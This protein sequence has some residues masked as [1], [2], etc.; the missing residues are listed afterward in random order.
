MNILES[1]GIGKK[2]CTA[3]RVIPK[4]NFE[5][6]NLVSFMYCM[7]CRQLSLDGYEYNESLLHQVFTEEEFK[8]IGSI[9][10]D[11]VKE[12]EPKKFER[13]RRKDDSYDFHEIVHSFCASLKNKPELYFGILD[14]ACS[15]KLENVFNNENP[16]TRIKN[17]FFMANFA[18]TFNLNDSEITFL[19]LNL[20]SYKNIWFLPEP[21][22][23]ENKIK[24]CSRFLP[25]SMILMEQYIKKLNKRF[26]KLALFSDDWK[27]SDYVYNYFTGNVYPFKVTDLHAQEFSDY[28]SMDSIAAENYGDILM[29]DEFV[30]K[31]K[32]L[33]KG[34]YITVSNADTFR[35][36][37]F[38]TY[39]NH[40]NKLFTAEISSE[41]SNFDKSA[42]IFFLIAVSSQV[43]GLDV[44]LLLGKN[45]LLNFFKADT[46]KN[47]TIRIFTS[48]AQNKKE[49]APETPYDLF[50]YIHTPVFLLTDSLNSEEAK[51]VNGELKTVYNWDLKNPVQKEYEEQFMEFLRTKEIDE[52]L[53]LYMA[54]ECSHLQIAP[55]KWNDIAT[56]V[57]ILKSPSCEKVMQLINANYSSSDL[58]K[59][60]RKN[61]HYSL[62]A[63]K[64][65]EPVENIVKD[66]Q[67]AEKWQSKEYDSESG[68]RI[69]NYGPS[70]T[71]KT[72][73]VENT[74]KL[75]D[76][77]LKIVRASEILGMYVGETE[78]NIK[79]AFEDAAETNSILLIDEADSFLHSRGD[80]VNRHNDSKVNE[81][82]VQME[83]FPG[84]LFCN[85]NLPDNL[86]SA[87]DRRFH[88]KI[89]FE[90]LDKEG[91]SL[92]CKSYFEKYEFSE[93][94]I[95]EIYNSGEVTPGDFGSLFGRMRFTDPDD[96]TADFICDE[97]IKVV[98][99]KKRSWKNR[100][101]IGFGG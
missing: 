73:F 19:L 47:N 29:T 70:G 98:K 81:F 21:L 82:L 89:G 78:K 12:K 43:Q 95:N 62:D 23:F 14:Y 8:K 80:N 39:I 90:P 93:Q 34:C 40:C 69:L 15:Q 97:L 88:M 16:F 99:G 11:V 63:L 33:R 5:D 54:K 10:I 2:S 100:K 46:E 72:A 38:V 76:K 77:P 67:N 87:T 60:I 66:L 92:L 25:D 6:K 48:S 44:V 68:I 32:K 37:N 53:I 28:Y 31:C 41:I 55:E 49:P 64:T 1:F 26:I 56:L 27:V 52:A 91:I 20:F 13:F 74:A 35:S 101:A 71:G 7:V 85:T 51:L 57:S 45:I 61:S 50:Q 36:K 59:N 30:L 17:S 18:N 24:I 58:K 3:E 84:I 79:Q 94:Q 4:F 96:V 9:Y 86:D 22:S 83:R 75:L 42:F 65:T